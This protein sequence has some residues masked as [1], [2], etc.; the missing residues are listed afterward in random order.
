LLIVSVKG[1]GKAG[2][3][4]ADKGKFIVRAESKESKKR[5]E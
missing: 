5:G 1:E 2:V 3:K 4:E